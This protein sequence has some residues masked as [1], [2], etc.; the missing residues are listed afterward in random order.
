MFVVCM[1]SI[2]FETTDIVTPL[3]RWRGEH[4]D[5]TATRGGLG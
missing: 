1:A 4:T 3:P 5:T 2:Q